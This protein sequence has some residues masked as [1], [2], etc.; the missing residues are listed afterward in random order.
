M[1]SVFC[2]DYRVTT[3]MLANSYIY[4]IYPIFELI[5]VAYYCWIRQTGFYTIV[6]YTYNGLI[7][8]VRVAQFVFCA[9]F[10][11]ARLEVLLEDI[12]YQLIAQRKGKTNTGALRKKLIDFKTTY[13]EI[14][15]LVS[16]MN[17][18]ARISLLIYA[19]FCVA[20]S[21]NSVYYWVLGITKGVML[22]TDIRKFLYF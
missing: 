3:K 8:S 5:I 2:L 20:L 15:E 19:V 12:N 21:I 9:N 6:I 11:R 7:I 10:I 13:E 1:E 16:L 17:H 22:M 14:H 4:L 18:C